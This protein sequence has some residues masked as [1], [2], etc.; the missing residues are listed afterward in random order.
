VPLRG[1]YLALPLRQ[2]AEQLGGTMMVSNFVSS[3]DGRIA[4]RAD[5]N[6]DTIP[7]S[8]ANP[9]D[10]R[11]LQELAAQSDV[12]ITSARYYRQ[13]AMNQQQGSVAI[14]LDDDFADIRAWRAQQ[15]MKPQ[16]D[17][18]IISQSLDIP[19]EPLLQ[20][21]AQQRR[22]TVLCGCQSSTAQQGVL[23]Q[24][25]ISVVCCASL[26]VT[27]KDVRD[28]V[29]QQCYSIA[30]MLAGPKV[31]STLLDDGVLDYL[32]LTLR[33]SLIGQDAFN[34]ITAGSQGWPVSMQLQHLFHDANTQQLFACYRIDAGRAMPVHCADHKRKGNHMTQDEMKEKVAE[35]ALSYVENGTIVG[36]GTGST[37]NKF[38]DAL[39][40]RKDDIIGTV[41]SSEATAERLRSHGI[42]V[43]DLNDALKQVDQLSV[44]I[45]G[46]DEFDHDNN[47]TKGGG[48]ALTR[49]KIVACASARFICIVDK[50]K[51]VEHLGAFPLPIEVIPMAESYVASIAR[52]LGGRPVKREGF[53]TDNG[54]IILDVHDMVITDAPALEER[55]NHVP[56]VVT[57]GIFS[58]FSRKGDVVLMGT[59]EGV[60]VIER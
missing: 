36:V 52:S 11:L 31:H 3:L 47:L 27:G 29:R 32:F 50:S 23:L 20:L 58:R 54:N 41:A 8:I 26:Q 1:A 51:Q 21:L 16:P 57:C 22:V 18:M 14:G 35:A 48:G 4:V 49:E 33:H 40:A 13:W 28:Y 56:G 42:A 12:L 45:D 5:D 25:G 60:E 30:C 19:L 24:H 46:A 17:V 59:P 9:R 7:D 6:S 38:I 2:W 37:A 53:V 43:L 10:W 34:S 55:L 39:A 44:Y 15:G